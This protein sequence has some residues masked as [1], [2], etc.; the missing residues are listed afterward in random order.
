[1][2]VSELKGAQLDYWVARAAGIEHPPYLR[3]MEPG[4]CLVK[5]E[6]QD[7]EG[8]VMR[9]VAFQPSRNWAQGG[10][11]FSDGLISA[12]YVPVDDPENP[13]HWEAF[14]RA[15]D[16]DDYQGETELEAR[17]RAYV[18]SKF[19]AEVPDEVPA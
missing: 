6:D 9:W 4:C 10:Q 8:P 7:D 13:G 16:D 3:K 14:F 17:A 18:A 12:I 1:M 2:K 5:V 15:V 19:G 11:L